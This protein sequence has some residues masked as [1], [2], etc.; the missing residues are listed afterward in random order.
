M[1]NVPTRQKAGGFTL[2]ELLVV[3]W[4]ISVLLAILVPAL[5]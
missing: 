3:F 5:N 1:K 4:F 2:V